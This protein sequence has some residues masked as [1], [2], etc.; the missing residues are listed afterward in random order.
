M[1][2]CMMFIR[3]IIWRRGYDGAREG[4]GGGD[5]GGGR[6]FVLFMLAVEYRIEL[7]NIHANFDYTSAEFQRLSSNVQSYVLCYAKL[8][9]KKTAFGQKGP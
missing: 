8:L 6:T 9:L 2:V 3:G 1:R 7:E 5:R 4:W